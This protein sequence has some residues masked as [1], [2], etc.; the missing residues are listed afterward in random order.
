MTTFP[1]QPYLIWYSSVSDM[2]IPSDTLVLAMNK[3]PIIKLLVFFF[4]NN[5][6]N[7]ADQLLAE[8]SVTQNQMPTGNTAIAKKKYISLFRL[9]LPDNFHVLAAHNENHILVISIS[10]VHFFSFQCERSVQNNLYVNCNFLIRQTC[11]KIYPGE[12]N[13]DLTI[14]IFQI[15][16]EYRY[17]LTFLVNHELIV[18]TL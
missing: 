4:F 5:V 1:P 7:L 2:T 15:N 16:V 14:R 13:V 11:K 10:A 17:S 18:W 9:N 3:G 6:T 12:L 8:Y